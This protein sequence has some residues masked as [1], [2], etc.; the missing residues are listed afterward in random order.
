MTN[1]TV[2]FLLVEDDEVDI[3]VIKRF[4][5]T[6]KMSNPIR[7]ARD[8]IE[9]LDILRGTNGQERIATPFLILLDINMPRMN[10]IEFLQELR[11]DAELKSA[12]VFVLT[13]S[14]SEE[15]RTS[16]YNQNVAGYFLKTNVQ[17]SFNTYLNMLD[18]Y[19]KVVKFP[20]G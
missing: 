4:F 2:T 1:T 15:D 6:R 3:K 18:Q 11:A 13:T 8:G 7:I 14:A 9:A 20:Q 19:W 12:I 10:G 16:A 17:G 5:R